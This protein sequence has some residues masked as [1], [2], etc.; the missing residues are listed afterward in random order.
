MCCGPVAFN[1]RPQTKVH[2][3]HDQ[4][5]QIIETARS[6]AGADT[7]ARVV[8][9][10]HQLRELSLDAIQ[11]FQHQY[12]QFIHQASR[13]DLWGAAYLMNGGCSDDG[14]RYFCH[15]LI[16]EGR[17]RF[18]ASLENPDSL[19]ELPKQDYFELESFAYVA[20]KVYESKG[21][22]E[23]DQGFSIELASPSGEEWSEDD[24]PTLFPR[25]AEKYE[26]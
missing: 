2:M 20:G 17:S 26:G 18:E 22:G 14:F 19:A 24:L 10:E 7:E 15:W 21:G 5:W 13:W 11:S 16:S 8:A 23:L 9:L 4:F 1:V 25:L 6:K 3:T 12:D